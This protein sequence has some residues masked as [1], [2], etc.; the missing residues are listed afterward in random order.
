M[1]ILIIGGTGLVSGALVE[2]LAEHGHRIT[3]YTR[4]RDHHRFVDAEPEVRKIHGDRNE[5]AQFARQ[6]G[7]E[8][9]DVVIDT[10]CYNAADAR[11]DV[12]IFGGRC[13]RLIMISTDF[14]YGTH[15]THLPMHEG[16]P[17]KPV[18]KYGR[19]K[20]S[21]E[22]VFR[23]AQDQKKLDCVIVRSPHIYG[24][25]APLGI[26]SI[27]GRSYQTADQIRSDH[28]VVILDDGIWCTQ[29][30]YNGDVARGV[31]AIIA[32]EKT[33]GNIYHLAGPRVYRAY[34]YYQAIGKAVG[35]APRFLS[36]P[37]S[38]YL[39][40]FTRVAPYCFH[41]IY[42]CS[43]LVADTGFQ[44]S[45]DIDDAVMRTL[46]WQ[47][48]SNKAQPYEPNKLEI[49]LIAMLEYH[50]EQLTVLLRNP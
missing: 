24:P 36:V 3:T 46:D 12:E 16:F 18:S 48:R 43:R 1:D 38:L 47:H 21:A 44:A 11:A 39:R 41:R 40:Y 7:D 27:R 17:T 26:G 9:Y 29:P 31:A 42:D 33:I 30:I 32:S 14:V 2:H 5:H 10:I 15:A 23:Q 13:G 35:A 6:M 20:L 28:P 49:A 37:S 19:N 4:G 34:E 22:E 50:L 45:V 25:G 8:K